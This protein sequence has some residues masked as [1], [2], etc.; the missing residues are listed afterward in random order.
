MALPLSA[1]KYLPVTAS[2]SGDNPI[3]TAVTGKKI[4]VLSYVLS[5]SGSVNAKW[6]SGTTDISGL[7]YTAATTNAS[8]TAPLG[9]FE[10]AAGQALNLNLSA[11]VP[12]GGHLTY[13]EVG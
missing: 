10:T 4:R 13:V 11:A 9:L 2:S 5:S 3:V 8:S 7:I 1:P 12:M 6:R